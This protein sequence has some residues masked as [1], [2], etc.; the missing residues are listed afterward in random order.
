[1]K[2]RLACLAVF[3]LLLPTRARGDTLDADPN[4]PGRITSVRKGVWELDLVGL[5]VLT[6]DTENGVSTTRLSTDFAATVAY[7]LRKNV[8]V[9]ASARANH[10]SVGG[11]VRATTFG[12]SANVV[13]HARLGLGAFFRPG[14]GVGALFGSRRTPVGTGMLEEAT[15]AGFITRVQLPI[16][17]FASKRLLLQAG[18][19][20]NVTVGGYTPSGGGEARAFTRVAGGFSVGAGYTF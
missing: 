2:L 18:P 3:F 11:G 16:A 17:Y 8:S 7:F 12:A 5:G 6:S 13:L 15:Q 14:I 19:Q 1:M 9:G 20:L 10:E 4:D